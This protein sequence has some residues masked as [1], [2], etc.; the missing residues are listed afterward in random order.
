MQT[1]AGGPTGRTC[2]CVDVVKGSTSHNRIG[3]KGKLK[4]QVQQVCSQHHSRTIPH[5]S[6]GG[7]FRVLL[8]YRSAGRICP[9]RF[10]CFSP[11]DW[12]NGRHGVY[13]RGDAIEDHITC[14][15]Y[16]YYNCINAKLRLTQLSHP[17]YRTNYSIVKVIL[18]GY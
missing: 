14:P 15:H 11:F 9:L 16:I 1:A 8:D 5:E 17:T 7:V 12:Q 3:I 13:E 10:Q 4:P 6:L 2:L 18:K